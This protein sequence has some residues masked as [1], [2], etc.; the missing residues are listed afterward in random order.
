MYRRCYAF[1]TLRRTR[2]SGREPA[3]MHGVGALHAWI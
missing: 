3:R 2:R 1:V